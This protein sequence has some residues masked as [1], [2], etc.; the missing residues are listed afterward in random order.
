MIPVKEFTAFIDK[1]KLD[2]MD[3]LK[4]QRVIPWDSTLYR[5]FE[6]E[7][8]AVYQKGLQDFIDSYWPENWKA[9]LAKNLPYRR[10]CLVN[11]FDI[12]THMQPQVFMTAAF[13]KPGNHEYIVADLRHKDNKHIAMHKLEAGPRPE[14]VVN[15]ERVAK[16]VAG[17]AFNR[18]R[19]IW[20]AWP[21]EDDSLFRACIQ[22]DVILW[23]V[24]RLVKDEA[25]YRAVVEVLLRHAKLLAHL[26]TFLAG[27]S[28]WP[29][30]GMLDLA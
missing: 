3:Q 19:S 1:R 15:F 4:K 21:A 22:H 29:S 20:G 18:G 10:P 9:A 8:K 28:S 2:Y 25:D 5:H 11:A 26:F 14:E 16:H 13:V 12:D 24:P 17:D 30:I 7:Y 23:K 27:R 6:D